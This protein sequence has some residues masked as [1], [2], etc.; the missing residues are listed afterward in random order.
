MNRLILPYIRIKIYPIFRI[1]LIIPSIHVTVGGETPHNC[2]INHISL[3]RY[4]VKIA[5]M[6]IDSL[7]VSVVE[8]TPQ[9]H[10]TSFSLAVESVSMPDV[11]CL[12]GVR[13]MWRISQLDVGLELHAREI[14]CWQPESIHR[15]ESI[16]SSSNSVRLTFH[17]SIES[18]Q[19]VFRHCSVHLNA[20]SFVLSNSKE[21]SGSMNELALKRKEDMIIQLSGVSF[22]SDSLTVSTFLFFYSASLLT[23]LVEDIR[24][25]V[26]LLPRSSCLSYFYHVLASL[27]Q[28]NL[29]PSPR[30][31]FEFPPFRYGE[32]A[33]MTHSFSLHIPKCEI[34]FL[35]DILGNSPGSCRHELRS[36]KSCDHLVKLHTS[37]DSVISEE[38]WVVR[39][40]D[41]QVE[42]Q[43]NGEI[44]S[45]RI[46][47][48]SG[49]SFDS[50][51]FLDIFFSGVFISFSMLKFVTIFRIAQ[52]VTFSVWCILYDV[53][54]EVYQCAMGRWSDSTSSLRNSYIRNMSA[55][56]GG[57]FPYNS[58]RNQSL[59]SARL[60][61]KLAEKWRSGPSTDGWMIDR[62]R[63]HMV[64][65]ENKKDD[66]T[67]RVNEWGGDHMPSIE[68]FFNTVFIRIG[69]MM[70]VEVKR[71]SL[72]KQFLCD[73]LTKEFD[74]MMKISK[75]IWGVLTS[76]LLARME[77]CGEPV[78]CHTNYLF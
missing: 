7:T 3:S 24:S 77:K 58:L 12:T 10:L 71:I 40:T 51:P 41:T 25:I 73:S 14:L 33:L 63:C 39:L 66:W 6:S 30:A 32:E 26:R 52:E 38:E 61:E 19:L 18:L 8:V 4:G 31:T 36:N 54:E 57:E 45:L 74:G 64:E 53:L 43:S 11:I 76:E 5:S 67:I 9:S 68:F 46:C 55:T 20:F 15:I 72:C 59:S 35:V 22:Q 21:V 60:K 17:V 50:I 69:K 78:E 70:E 1:Y 29:K 2:I 34:Y 75:E 62:I 28:W 48:L 16:S 47:S 13:C 56:N 44:L 42:D 37:V 23:D 27:N 49:F 65:V